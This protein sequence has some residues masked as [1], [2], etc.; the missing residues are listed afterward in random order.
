[1]AATN[2]VVGLLSVVVLL[3]PLSSARAEVSRGAML[4]NSCAGC[5][6]T[7]GR[8][9]KR[10]PRLNDLEPA[11]IIELMQGFKEGPQ[12]STIMHRHAPGY[13]DEEIKLIAEYLSKSR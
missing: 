7:D 6:G 4:A 12:G 8:G 2:F 3:L 11:D 1:M 5:H 10:I 9:S 13:T